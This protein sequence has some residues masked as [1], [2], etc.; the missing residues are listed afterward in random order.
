VKWR[1]GE[2]VAVVG[3]SVLESLGLAEVSPDQNPIPF[4]EGWRRRFD[5]VSSFVASA[6]RAPP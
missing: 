6:W 3:G 5:V 2:L 4:L 1:A